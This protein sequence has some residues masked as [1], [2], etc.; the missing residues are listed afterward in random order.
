[1]LLAD[2]T[3]NYLA[4]SIENG[5]YDRAD[6]VLP[7]PRAKQAR[8]DEWGQAFSAMYRNGTEYTPPELHNMR[9]ESVRVPICCWYEGTV[10]A[11]GDAERPMS[12]S[13]NPVV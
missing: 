2:L 10:T 8:A 9:G 4:H 12:G 3:A 13:L 6:S 11:D 5:R 7:V 1:M